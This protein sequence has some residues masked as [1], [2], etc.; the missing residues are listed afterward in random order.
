MRTHAALLLAV[1]LAPALAQ[2]DERSDKIARGDILVETRPMP[3][4]DTPTII[5]TALVASPPA[6]VWDVLERCGDYKKFMPRM[7]ESAEL[8]RDGNVVRCKTVV[9]SPWPVEDLMA[10]TRA[11]HVIS[12]GKWLRQWVLES[13]DYKTITGSWTLTPYQGD[14]SRTLVVYSIHT[15]PKTG[16]PAF[17]REFAQKSALPDVIKALRV[18]AKKRE[19]AVSAN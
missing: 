18:E 4:S 10:I 1:V 7:A 11:E 2:A 12:E 15:E 9:D 13:G 19:A 16:L 3:G 6:A 8:S 14:A 17:V 5:V